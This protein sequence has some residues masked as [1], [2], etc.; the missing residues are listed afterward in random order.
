MTL[1]HIA[2][3]QDAAPA[4]DITE[5]TLH[6]VDPQ[7]REFVQTMVPAELNEANLSQLRAFVDASPAPGTENPPLEV[8]DMPGS[9]ASFNLLRPET[10]GA[11]PAPAIV[12]IHGGGYV[13]GQAAGYDGYCYDM[14]QRTGAVVA[15]VEYRLAPETP[16][17]GPVTDCHDVLVYLYENAADL[18]IDSERISIMGHSA[19]G[20]LTAALAHMARDLGQVP[21]KAQFPI[22]PM[23]DYRT[24]TTAAPVNNLTTGEYVWGRQTN[25]FGWDSLRGSYAVDDERKGWFSPTHADTMAGLPPT[26]MIVGALDLFMEE[27]AAYALEL[28]RASVPVDFAIYPGA[29]HGFDLVPGT[30]LTTRFNTD[31][32]RAFDRLL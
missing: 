27:G 7:Y 15:N 31:L 24:G 23:L 8:F 10:L 11:T 18:G 16:F 2:R 4:A 17:P 3:A 9:A 29:T 5:S 25:R 21:V 20:G 32:K 12:Y 6:L 14:A 28:S 1:P 30:T 19:G 22:Y 13:L 26:F